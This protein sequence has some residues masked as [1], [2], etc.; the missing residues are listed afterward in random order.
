MNFTF[1]HHWFGFMLCWHKA[2]CIV[3]I[4]KEQENGRTTKLKDNAKELGD[5]WK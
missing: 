3:K 2:P 4:E 5:A 1:D